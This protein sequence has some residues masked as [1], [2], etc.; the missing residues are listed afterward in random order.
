VTETMQPSLLS[1]LIELRHAL[2]RHPELS[3][4]EENTARQI[5]N[6]LSSYSPDSIIT[7]L[8]GFGVAAVYRG[9]E[10]GPVIMI[11]ADMDALHINEVNDIPYRSRIKGMSHACGHDGHMAV[12][13]GL[14][15]LL[16][17]NRPSKGAVILLFQPAEENARGARNV[18]DD[19]G[20]A[21]ISPDY[22]FALHNMPGH[23]LHRI[24]V[25]EDTMLSAVRTIIIRLFGKTAHASMPETG[26]SPLKA[27]KEIEKKIGS[28]QN[29]NRTAADFSMATIV[30]LAV[31]EKPSYGVSPA[32]GKIIAT[33]RA[34][35]DDILDRLSREIESFS[36]KTATS[37]KLHVDEISYDEKYPATVNSRLCNNIIREAAAGNNLKIRDLDYP[38]AAGEDFGELIRASRRGGAMFFIGAGAGAPGLHNPDYDFP[39]AIIKTGLDMLWSIIQKTVETN[40]N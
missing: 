19:P 14:A 17:E 3:C 34:Y 11:R 21:G 22:T 9:V 10:D 36:I 40:T 18:I 25:R 32:D 8:G 31:G 24:L 33:L 29:N 4:H 1:R 6:F 37:E 39:D 23:P 30:G 20:F 12:A 2:H 15:P 28:L 35:T 16:A 13:A 5:V 7:G 27:I 26:I 38:L